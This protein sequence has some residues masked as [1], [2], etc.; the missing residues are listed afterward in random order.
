M[1][2][3][4]I[5]VILSAVVLMIVT[6]LTLVLTLGPRVSADDGKRTVGILDKAEY[7][8][9][10]ENE[11]VGLSLAGNQIVRN[12]DELQV[13]IPTGVKV[14]G[15]YWLCDEGNNNYNYLLTS[16]MLPDT[17]VSIEDW[18]F[19]GT[20]ITSIE[21]PASVRGIGPR[22]FANC[23][24]LRSIFIPETVEYIGDSVFTGYDCL[25]YCEATS[26][27]ENW[28]SFFASRREIAMNFDNTY[29]NP[30]WWNCKLDGHM[31]YQLAEDGLSYN[32]VGC[33]GNVDNVEIG[34]EFNHLPVKVID[35]GA[36]MGCASL[37]S[38]VIPNGVT[39][40]GEMAFAY[41]N[42]RS[43]FIPE[44]VEFMEVAFLTIHNVLFFVKQAVVLM[45]GMTT[46]VTKMRALHLC[47]WRLKIVHIRTF[48]GI[49][50]W[51]A[52]LFINLL[53]TQM[54]Y[55]VMV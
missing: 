38:I 49:V 31:V 37:T 33:V 21:L 42:F 27:P 24:F 18:A 12:C 47:L 48:I 9:I 26:R 22:A 53:K 25:I 36:F 39:S 10:E 14:I 52:I 23:T 50:N 2:K 30:V 8:E 45:V 13:I 35:D 7:F 6:S 3:K 54:V 4:G 1:Q 41:D 32:M 43:I 20:G 28:S 51:I 16:V 19:R 44:T 29:G 40:I 17:L 46:G 55:R 34:S 5:I 11:I 15:R